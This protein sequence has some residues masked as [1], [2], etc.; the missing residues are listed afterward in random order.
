MN[1]TKRYVFPAIAATVLLSMGLAGCARSSGNTTATAAPDP[2]ITDTQ[3]SLGT[4]MPLSGPV[5][6][7]GTQ[8]LAGLQAYFDAANANGGITFGDGK[9][10]KVDLKSYD[11]GYDPARAAADFRQEIAEGK[12]ANVGTLGTPNNLAIMPLAKSEKMPSVLL[13]SG[14]DLL[15]IDQKA[16]PWV[17]GFLPTQR[18]EG[19]A[20]GKYLASLGKPVTIAVLQQ[21]D[22]A[23][24]NYVDGLT[25][26]IKGSQAKIVATATFAVTDP[27]VDAQMSKLADSKADFFFEANPQPNLAPQS[28]LK[29]QQLGWLPEIFLPSAVSD[30]RQS[31]GP[32]NASA[33]PGVYSTVFSKN[34]NVAEFA[35]EADVVQ[36]NADIKKYAPANVSANTIGQAVWGY[37]IGATMKA[38]FEKMKTP[39]R[40]ALMDAIHQLKGIKLPLALDG[41][42]LDATSRTA[43]PLNDGLKLEKYDFSANK[44]NVIG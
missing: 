35:N 4:I 21:N 36:F 13:Q 31:L 26:G 2:G 34:P 15:S 17:I 19:L 39:T 6:A 11:D 33:F 27:T 8:A 1:F 30:K 32:G 43:S 3:I 40:Q 28:I 7:P 20:F 38:A 18:S 10:R 29:A 25:E 23:G 22:D 12:F 16:N 24:Q 42:T 41:V 5:A 9:T 14:S 44:Y 37:Q